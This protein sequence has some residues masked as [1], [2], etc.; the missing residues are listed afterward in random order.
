MQS[1][2][3]RAGPTRSR[4]RSRCKL[5]D[6]ARIGVVGGGPAGSFFSIFA[7][8]MAAR[9][10]LRLSVDVFE[11]RDF[12]LRGPRGCN[13]CGGIVSESLV[14]DLAA[15]GISLPPAV[16]QRGIDSYVLHTDVGEVR[17][18]TPMSE[19]R[20]AA[21]HRGLGPLSSEGSPYASFDA[22]L[23]GEAERRGANVVRRRIERVNR[24][25]GLPALDA[26]DGVKLRYDLVVIACGVNGAAARLLDGLGLDG[27]AVRT[28]RALIR[29][30]FVGRPVIRKSLG[31][32]MHVFLLNI[33]RLEFAALI[34][35]GEYVS[36][37]MLGNEIDQPLLD[38]FLAAREVT[39]CMPAGWQSD[40]QTCRC[41]PRMNV[42]WRG[43][44]YGERVL[45][46]GDAGVARLYKDG[47]GSA[48]RTAKAAACAAVLEGVSKADFRL[49]YWPACR[50]I[51]RD[52]ALGRVVFLVVRQFQTWRFA[53]RALLGLIAREQRSNGRPARMSL[54]LWNTFTGSAPY[55]EIVRQAL[56]PGLLARLAV[57]MAGAAIG[58]ARTVGDT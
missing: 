33:P 51:A 56:R 17:I 1:Q 35:K 9:V 10:G 39:S 49:R 6:G 42:G 20:I 43:R 55:R 54:V 5:E 36:L 30:Y 47:I 13:M 46:V 19:K 27:A 48:Y 37:C 26:G 7:L 21:V 25:D 12:S 53:R 18:G 50:A 14:E 22:F 23:L 40:E 16:I 44:P 38:S 34:P 11:H 15:E 41:A 2:V 31:D 32:S 57:E 45:L 24:E 3:V 52:N 28:T 29:E 4:R 8:D 58:R